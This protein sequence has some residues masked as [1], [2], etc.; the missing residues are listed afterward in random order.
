MRARGI[1]ILLLMMA[2]GCWGV[3]PTP[4]TAQEHASDSTAITPAAGEAGET[5]GSATEAGGH[6]DEGEPNIFAGRLLT[7]MLTV[8][9]FIVL[10]LILGKWAWKPMLSGLQRRE[11]HI[12]KT[13]EDAEAKQ[14]DAESR[15]EE[16][17]QKLETAQ[18]EAQKILEQGRSEAAHLAEKYR[19]QAHDDAR[20]LQQKAQRDIEAAREAAVRQLYRESYELAVKL[21]G[22]IIEEEVS[23]ERHERLM[24]E[25]LRQVEHE[26]G[27]NRTAD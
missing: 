4:A 11:E 24:E 15:L 1:H 26:A 22:R 20:Q 19:K 16:Y 23:P 9:V 10:L 12:R 8:A 21:A 7:S 13:I 2:L 3:Q 6:E 5:H 27:K 25:A 14:A 17:R 18:K